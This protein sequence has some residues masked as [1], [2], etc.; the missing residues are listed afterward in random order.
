M[1][2]TV[3]FFDGQ[4]IFHAAREAFGHTYPN[5]NP[6]ALAAALCVPRGWTLID[7]RFYTGVPEA[8]DDAFWNH[9]WKAK[10]RQMSR[11]GV[12]TYARSL[13]YRNR[14]VVFPDGSTGPAM[15]AEEKG[16]DVRIALDIVRLAHRQAF[17][18]ALVFML[19]RSEC[20]LWCQTA[21]S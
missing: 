9:F 14:T 2:R 1:K 5:Y 12:Q 7:T 11:S 8:R 16:I 15:V 21:W 19:S 13:K 10:L 18:V 20:A 6:P 17:D 3:A 4:N